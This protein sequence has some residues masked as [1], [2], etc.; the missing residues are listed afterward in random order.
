MIIITL[1]VDSISDKTVVPN[2]PDIIKPKI[3]NEEFVHES[4]V[5]NNPK[6]V[7]ISE[8]DDLDIDVGTLMTYG[9]KLLRK[10]G[11]NIHPIPYL[12]IFDFTGFYVT[13]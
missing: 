12:N 5:N 4:Y 2:V 11:S 13:K 9:G 1:E 7:E 6:P 3:D 10:I 8:S